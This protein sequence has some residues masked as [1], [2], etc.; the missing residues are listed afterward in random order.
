MG[1]LEDTDRFHSSLY[2]DEYCNFL[3]LAEKF[4][5]LGWVY[6]LGRFLVRAEKHK[7]MAFIGTNDYQDQGISVL[8]SIYI[9][10]DNSL[11]LKFLNDIFLLK[12]FQNTEW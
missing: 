10:W 3:V 7:S 9:H 2:W 11:H 5:I 8:L 12:K 1:T 6:S 4:T